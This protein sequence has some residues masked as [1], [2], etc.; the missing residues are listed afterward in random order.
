MREEYPVGKGA[1]RE[2][3]IRAKLFEN[4][5]KFYF[6]RLSLEFSSPNRSPRYFAT[7][8]RSIS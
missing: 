3:K 1:E 8:L 5:K 7:V 2:H 4:R 6:F